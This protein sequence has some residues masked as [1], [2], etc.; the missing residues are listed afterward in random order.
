MTLF[1]A[2]ENKYYKVTA[3]QTADEELKDRLLSLGITKNTEVFLERFSSN[4][5]TL[6]IKINHSKVALRSSE[7]Q[8]III[9]AV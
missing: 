2:Q 9:E 3:I 5:Y 1:E 7:A 8:H 6:A 4:K